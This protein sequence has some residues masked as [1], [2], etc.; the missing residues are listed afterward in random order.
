M[1]LQHSKLID[2]HCATGI[3]VLE[4]RQEGQV[5]QLHSIKLETVSQ[6][7]C[8]H[9]VLHLTVIQPPNFMCELNS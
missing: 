6:Y 5:C 3:C 2:S 1:L 9:I 8:Y 4:L 7:S